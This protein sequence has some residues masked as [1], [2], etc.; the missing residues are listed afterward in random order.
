MLISIAAL[1]EFR[2]KKNFTQ[3]KST[4]FSLFGREIAT[5][6]IVCSVASHL[7]KA[8]RPPEYHMYRKFSR[9]DEDSAKRL[10]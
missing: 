2:T 8:L 3:S 10:S 1:I 4:D 5:F 7:D 9:Y 6:S